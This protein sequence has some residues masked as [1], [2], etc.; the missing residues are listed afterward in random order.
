[1]GVRYASVAGIRGYMIY[2]RD[3]GRAYTILYFPYFPARRDQ[4]I[5]CRKRNLVEIIL[6]KHYGNYLTGYFISVN[7]N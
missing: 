6:L 1:M 4:E 3:A 7:G 2:H 5:K